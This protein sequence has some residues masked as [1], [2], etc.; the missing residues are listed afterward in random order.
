MAIIYRC[1]H[2]KT[3]LAELDE[4]K[5]D[6]KSLG[7]DQLSAVDYQEMVQ[8]DAGNIVCQVSCEDCE[9]TLQRYPHYHELDHFMQ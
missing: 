5:V 7:W 9:N 3:Q 4:Y 6:I 8:M 1:R 2:C